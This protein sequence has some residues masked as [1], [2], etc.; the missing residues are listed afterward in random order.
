MDHLSRLT[1]SVDPPCLAWVH[2]WVF[3]SSLARCLKFTIKPPLDTINS[4]QSTPDK[5][6]I[7]N[8]TYSALYSPLTLSHAR[9]GGP[10]ASLPSNFGLVQSLKQCRRVCQS[11]NKASSLVTSTIGSKDRKLNERGNPLSLYPLHLCRIQGQA[12]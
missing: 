9:D 7:P 10:S 12:V 1:P 6:P 3:T 5:I 4:R 8:K 11:I 2:E